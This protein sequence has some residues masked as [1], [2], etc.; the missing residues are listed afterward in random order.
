M[1]QNT[2]KGDFYSLIQNSIP[3]MGNASI[4]NRSCKMDV[5]LPDLFI[6]FATK[7]IGDTICVVQKLKCIQA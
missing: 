7:T 4:L 6:L 2:Q 1:S 3:Y 5:Q